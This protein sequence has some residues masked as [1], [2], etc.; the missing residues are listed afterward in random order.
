MVR[1]R[2]S[3][4]GCM[5]TC[6]S[7]LWLIVAATPLACS[8]ASNG[9]AL[10]APA[11][12][13]VPSAPPTTPPPTGSKWKGVEVETDC[14]RTTLAWVAVDEMC[15][16]VDDP[17]YLD[18]LRAPMFRDGVRIGDRL[19]TVDG[20]QL[21]VLDVSDPTAPSRV[22]LLAGL[23][24]P[25]AVAAH[26]GHLLVA[27]GDAG[28]FV[29]DPD[30]PDGL[31]ETADLALEGPALGVAVAGDR[32]LV[33]L[34]HAGVALV[35][36]DPATSSPSLT[37]TIATP[38]FAVSSAIRGS[39]GYVAAC[40]TFARVDLDAGT[41]L[42]QSW[43]SAYDA[44]G[45]LIA[46]ARGV[47]LVGDEAFVAAG[48]NGAVAL[49]IGDSAPL[50]ILGQCTE[51][52]D[53]SFYASGVRAQNGTLY[54]AGGEWGVLPVDASA[55]GACPSLL[56]PTY[57]PSPGDSTTCSQDPPWQTLPWQD[58][59]Q[60]P[61]APAPGKDPV[62]T[63]PDGDRLFAFGDARR[64]AMRAV[65][66]RQT[67]TQ[68]MPNIGRYD[69]PRVITDL[70]AANGRV[71]V[72][73]KAAG[74]FLTDA[75]ALLVPASI[76]VGAESG[77]AAIMLADGRWAFATDATL[78]V[79]GGA[80]IALAEPAPLHGMSSRGQE[81]ALGASGGARLYDANTSTLTMVAAPEPAALPPA[82]LDRDDGVYLAAPEWT[83]AVR[84][85]ASGA[86][87]LDENGVFGAEEIMDANL[88]RQG[89]PRRLLVD[90]P[91]GLVEIASLGE[92]AGLTLHATGGSDVKLALP[93]ATYLDAESAG[94]T[95]Y[96]VTAE[97]STYRSTLLTVSLSD[98]GAAIS[99]VD[100]FT[101][102]A[103][104]LAVDGTRLYL[105]DADRGVRVY[106]IAAQ[107]PEALGVVELGGA[108]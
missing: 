45:T 43:L 64:N 21:W 12:P 89:L 37:Q 19:Y 4:R 95:L 22:G 10:G 85:D 17:D 61:P 101:G 54:V 80:P 34:G 32:A 96:I 87:E 18:S 73:G 70:A 103:A 13:G 16:G 5:R 90:S 50:S 79:E 76:P 102:V 75:N 94:S 40:D 7:W 69:E 83:R 93:T 9:S 11:D 39:L 52:W 92:H 27:A 98:A 42:D 33:A 8:A 81:I 60:P 47:A 66:V 31:A 106:D 99:H 25:L 78:Q 97:R 26:A 67:G 48:R 91:F 100:T 53:V 1:A 62:Q 84:L 65:D 74:L 14:G 15:A 51:Q 6:V 56:V 59:W 28:L 29:L 88:W 20:T 55:P 36:L 49:D 71:L 46:P 107:I 63:L 82:I 105:G 57:P 86:S 58:Q 77:V 35:A 3:V 30:G 2:G 72:V 41:V 24:H 38:G 68:A 23:G 104:A 108:P 44:N